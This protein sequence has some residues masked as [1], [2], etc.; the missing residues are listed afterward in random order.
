VH[1][2]LV[3]LKYIIL[4]LLFGLSLQ[5]ITEAAWYAEV[6]PF[7]TVISLRFQTRMELRAVCP[8]PDRRGGCEPQVLLQVP[9]SARRGAG[10]T[11]TLPPF[12]VV[13]ATTQ[14]VRQAMPGLRQPV[15]GAGHPA[16]GEINAN[17]CHYCLDCQVI[18]YNDQ[19]CL[20][21]IDRRKRREQQLKRG[22]KARK[23]TMK[24]KWL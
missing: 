21:L 16:T 7:K 23:K 19:V 20:P 8:D 17:E 6:E 1:E 11:R 2:R 13:A 24:T 15:F 14:G 22:Q 18:Y 10:D 5:S 12:R 3:A 9:L 4:I